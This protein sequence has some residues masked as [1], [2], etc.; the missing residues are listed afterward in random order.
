MLDL[1]QFDT[2]KL[3]NEGARLYPVLPGQEE[4]TDQMYLVVLGS[5]SDA[6]RKVKIAEARKEL[7]RKKGK[8]DQNEWSDDEL[9]ELIEGRTEIVATLVKDWHGVAINGKK[10]PCTPD[11][12]KMLLDQLPWL[13]RQVNTFAAQVEHF[14]PDAATLGSPE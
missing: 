14:L 4:P 13:K 11:N 8:R 2:S 3:A 7:A 5:D 6:F 1:S 10:L 12:V 9:L